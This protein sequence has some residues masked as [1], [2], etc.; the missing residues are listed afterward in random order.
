MP[1]AKLILLYL[2]VAI[3]RPQVC[4]APGSTPTVAAQAIAIVPAAPVA[5]TQAPIVAPFKIVTPVV[6]VTPTASLASLA[7]SIGK[8]I[9]PMA[10]PAALVSDPC[11]STDPEVCHQRELAM[12]AHNKARASHHAPALVWS[13]DLAAKALTWADHCVWKHSG[14]SLYPPSY[15]YGEN[16][17]SSTLEMGPSGT[18]TEMTIGKLSS[19]DQRIELTITLQ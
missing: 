2:G 17:Y 8:A 3:N 15:V 11:I 5:P 1:G 9:L 16:L 19:I 10:T 6:A 4:S 14:G 12:E 7:A 18:G 13:N